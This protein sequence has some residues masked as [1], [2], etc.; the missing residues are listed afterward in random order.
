MKD[1][2]KTRGVMTL[3]D[4]ELYIKH[5]LGET[6]STGAASEGLLLVLDDPSAG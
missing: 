2:K 1:P 5:Y 6:A 4:T 3:N